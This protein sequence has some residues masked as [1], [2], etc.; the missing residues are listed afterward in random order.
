MKQVKFLAVALG[1]VLVSVFSANA[2]KIGYVSVDALV[3]NLPEAQQKQQELQKWQQDSIGGT[4]TRLAQEF[5]E[6]DSAMKKATG[7]VK[8]V[9]ERDL[10]QL[11]ET[12]ANWQQIA[13]EASQAK[14]AQLFNPLYKKVYDAINA[15]AKEKG[16]TY[17]LTQDAFVVAPDSDN[18]S[19]PIATK[20]GIKVNPQGNA[21]APAGGAAPA[22]TTPKK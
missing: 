12:L 3:A 13:Q 7:S 15:Y 5:Q 8:Q 21:P 10:A 11:N 2:Q 19:L 4:Y 1:L 16:Y 6:K 17:V 9:L 18:L 22:S 20:L 14:Q